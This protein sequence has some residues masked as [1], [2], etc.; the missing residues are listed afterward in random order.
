MRETLVLNRNFYAVQICSWDKCM[1]LLYRG[2]ALAVDKDY[3]TYDFN[4]WKDLSQTMTEYPNGIVSAV[5]FKIAAPEIIQL[6]YFENLPKREVKFS[7]RTLYRQYNYKCCYCGKK[8]STESLNL[9][10]VTPR[11]R[12]GK[13]DWANLVLS[14]VRC[15][16]IKA[17]RTPE[18]AGMHMSYQ[19][20]KPAWTPS[21]AINLGSLTIKSSWEKF[22]NK[23]YWDGELEK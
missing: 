1:S 16:T 17:N 13:T 23:M 5:N 4:S 19:P 21:Y 12:G 9:D 14:C 15:N 11:S 6:T 2:Q 8:F 20:H 3:R 10:H 18:E 22:V 7:R